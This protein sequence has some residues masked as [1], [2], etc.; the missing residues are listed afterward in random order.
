MQ[1]YNNNT[2]GVVSGLVGGLGKFY[3]QIQ[4]PFILNIMGAILTAFLCGVAGMAGKE[5]FVLIRNHFK[6]SK[7]I[8]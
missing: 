6:K 3:L 8:S 4:T 5:L 7:N 2:I 1:D